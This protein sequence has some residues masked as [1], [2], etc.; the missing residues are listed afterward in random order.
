MGVEESGK[1]KLDGKKT[2][3]KVLREIKDYRKL[4]KEIEKNKRNIT[5]HIIRHTF[6]TNIFEG[7]VLR[8]K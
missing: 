8:K 7:S 1:N 4:L 3:L 6:I 2:N 5:E